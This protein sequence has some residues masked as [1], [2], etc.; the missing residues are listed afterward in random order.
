VIHRANDWLH[1]EWRSAVKGNDSNYNIMKNSRKPMKRSVVQ[2][3]IVAARQL[4]EGIATEEVAKRCTLSQELVLQV[5]VKTIFEEQK[6]LAEQLAV[7][8]RLYQTLVDQLQAGVV[9]PT[10]MFDV[11]HLLFRRQP[12]D[13]SRPKK[14]RKPKRSPRQPEEGP[15][16]PTSDH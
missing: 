6:Q 4:V 13:D 9:Y 11:D 1:P 8:Q 12:V 3:G 16:R 14:E 2:R 5:L 10:S 7:V 15:V